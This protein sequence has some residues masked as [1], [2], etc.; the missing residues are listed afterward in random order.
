MARV[1]VDWLTWL[2]ESR[3]RT[4]GA[5]R[6]QTVDPAALCALADVEAFAA[7]NLDPM[8]ID[9]IAHLRI[10]LVKTRPY[11]ERLTRHHPGRPFSITERDG[12]VYPLTPRKILRR[13]L[14]HTLDHHNQLQQWLDW[15]NA[16]L[17]PT[18]TDGWAPSGV[19]FSEDCGAVDEDEL[20]AWLW[21][22][23]RAV[24]MLIHDAAQL[25]QAQ[26]DWQPPDGGWT[27]DRVLHHV[28]RWYGYAAWL[29]EALT[30]DPWGRYAEAQQRLRDTVAY[31][32]SDPPP[33]DTAF[34][35]NAGLRFT[36]DDAMNDVLAAEREVQSTGRLSAAASE[37][38]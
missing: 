37:V 28:A 4:M 24:E 17:A 34:Y 12:Y 21:R 26:L 38:D 19:T 8:P 2:D 31:L 32:L 29:D 30:D 22:I 36:L 33:A 14:D 13:V 15:Q 18:P 10:G 11:L 16:G 20:L 1:G 27:L 35:G 9:P 23:D 5:V 6:D 3:A 7:L 25:S